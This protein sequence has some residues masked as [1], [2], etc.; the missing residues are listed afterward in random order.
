MAAVRDESTFGKRLRSLRERKG[1]RQIDLASSAGLSWRHLIRIE[2]DNGGVTKP[3]TVARL[4]E[5]LGVSER[6]L[7]GDDDSEP[8]P[9]MVTV[10]VQVTLDYDLLARA[11][12]RR[13]G[14]PVGVA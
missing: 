13:D 8:H 11:I 2:Q 4:A 6:D 14:S 12:A 7:T 9:A 3:T 5:A 1:I 10:P